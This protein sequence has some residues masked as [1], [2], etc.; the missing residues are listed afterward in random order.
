MMW[1]GPRL[2]NNLKIKGINH[3]GH[4]EA[5]GYGKHRVRTERSR[6]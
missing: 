3:R 4:R 5:Q 2:R 1:L 6:V